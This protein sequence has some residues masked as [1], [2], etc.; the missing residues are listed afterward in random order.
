MKEAEVIELM[1]ALNNMKPI[2]EMEAK[3]EGWQFL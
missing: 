3:K 1:V 2:A